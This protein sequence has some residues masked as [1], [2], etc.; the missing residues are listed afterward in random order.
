MIP[1]TEAIV[2]KSFDY[3]ETS[4]IVT[5]YT[6]ECGK[7]S[8]VMKGIRKDPRKFGS[9]VEKYSV[10]D[11]VYYHYSRSDLH[12]ISH[13]DMKQYFFSIRDHYKKNMAA[14]YILELVDKLM[15][16]EQVN[17]NVY[18]LMM[19]FLNQLQTEEDVDKLIYIFQIKV[20]R[21]AGFS[22]YLDSCVCCD[23]KVHGRARFSVTS[24]GLICADCPH[25]DTS[26]LGISPGTVSTILHI[27]AGSWTSCLRLGITAPVRKE[28]KYILNNF[29]VFHLDRRIRSAKFIS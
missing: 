26:Y 17:E 7:I 9:N 1:K 13:C 24:G 28:L 25:E 10:N 19:R 23:R 20:L 21:F 3:R 5:F 6:R 14:N 8:G 12:L 29:L 11:L 22:P 18:R 2:L 15:A 27:G 16:P 4:R